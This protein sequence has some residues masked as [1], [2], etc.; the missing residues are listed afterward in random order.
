MTLDAASAA[1]QTPPSAP[2]LPDGRKLDYH[3]TEGCGE[4]AHA[5]GPVFLGGSCSNVNAINNLAHPD[6]MPIDRK[7]R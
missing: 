3:R 4:G 6:A 5:P 2:A 1:T 7:Q